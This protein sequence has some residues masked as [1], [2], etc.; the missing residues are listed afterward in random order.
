MILGGLEFLIIPFLAAGAG[1]VYTSNKVSDDNSARPARSYEPQSQ[2][3]A[4]PPSYAPQ[5]AYNPTPQNYGYQPYEDFSQ[6]YQEYDSGPPMDEVRLSPT[7]S[8]MFYANVSFEG[9]IMEMLVDTGA[10][11]VA[12]GDR[13][14]RVLKRYAQNTQRGSASTADNRSVTTTDFT[15]PYLTVLSKDQ[16]SSV[17]ARDIKIQYIH[18]S[19]GDGLLGMAFLGKCEFWYEGNEFVIRG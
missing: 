11:N 19:K 6:G 16:R 4:P 7:G 8:M 1:T 9:N 15:I 12:I 18:G 17:T 10:T 13:E 5:Q 2:P 14:W 3:Y